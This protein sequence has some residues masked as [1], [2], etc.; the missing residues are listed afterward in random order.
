MIKNAVIY[1]LQAGWTATVE[2]LE[3]ALA[4]SRFFPCGATQERSIGWV[5]PREKAGAL[6]ESVGGQWLMKLMIESKSVPA[7]AVK[8]AVEERIAKYK[9]E[10]GR[11]RVG[12]KIKKEFKEEVTLDLMPRAFPRRSSVLVW[13]D[14]AAKLLV[15]DAGSHTRADEAVTE[16]V[17]TLCVN[18]FA[19]RPLST[20]DS[21]AACMASWLQAGEAPAGF[22]VDRD[23]QLASNDEDKATVRYARIGLDT[24]E[25][26]THIQQGKV[27]TLLAMTWNDRLSFVLT[28]AGIIKRIDYLGGIMETQ[29]SEEDDFDANVTLATGELG[30]FIPAL[31]EA[32]GG[33]QEPQPELDLTDAPAGPVASATPDASNDDLYAKAVAIV[34]AENKASISLVQRHLQIGYNHAAR[35][36]EEMEAK[37]VVSRMGTDGSRTVVAA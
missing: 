35:L 7:G 3:T 9:E 13:I 37:G 32:M 33:E 28:E 16:L 6:I 14:L 36:L 34:T 27:P 20:V 2:Q 22:T 8:A 10:T 1:R 21:P 18:G 15:I 4:G 30:A 31:I 5:A 11:E 17:N 26:R 24:E 19:P 12:A 29:K 23:C 25:V